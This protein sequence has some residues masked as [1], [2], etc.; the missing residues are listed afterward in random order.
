MC[1]RK[2]FVGQGRDF[3]KKITAVALDFTKVCL[4]S[5]ACDTLGIMAQHTL[6]QGL[7]LVSSGV[8]SR[9][10]GRVPRYS[11]KHDAGKRK[12]KRAAA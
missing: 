11:A 12:K 2:L 4:L 6:C 9:H 3:E 1:K 8:G 5:F 10:G 7:L